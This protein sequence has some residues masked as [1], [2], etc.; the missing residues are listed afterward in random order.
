MEAMDVSTSRRPV[1]SLPVIAAILVFAGGLLDITLLGDGDPYWHVEVGRWIASHHEVPVRDFYSYTFPGLAWTA[2]EWLS[3]LL[4]FWV[5]SIAGWQGINILVCGMFALTTAYMLRFLLDRMP[6]VSAITTCVVCVSVMTVHFYGRPHVF[7]WPMTALWVGTLVKAGE[8]HQPP[9]L[10]LLPM[11]IVWANLHASFTLGLGF[12]GALALDAWFLATPGEERNTLVR[13]WSIFL[14]A[15]GACVLINPRGIG[16]ITHAIGVMGMKETLDI[17]VEW[18]SADFHQFQYLLLWIA[19]VMIASLTG[20]LRLSP[21][22]IIFILGLLYLALK[23]RR[24]H[25][26]VGLVSPF[27]LARPLGEGLRRAGTTNGDGT[28]LGAVDGFPLAG[29]A[30]P[31]GAVI[32]V[33]AC[34]GLLF[35]LY[36]RIPGAPNPYI[37]PTA[38]LQAFRATGIRANVLNTYGFGGYLIYEHVPVFI[39]G[40]G[41]MYGD[42]FMQEAEDANGLKKPHALDSVLTKY[43]IGWTL[44]RPNTAAVELLDHLPAWERLYGDSIGVVHVRRDL[45]PATRP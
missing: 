7:V 6:A 14:A 15:A 25:A 35:S 42:K 29:R 5:W 13:R 20:R 45:M 40:R 8:E 9:P 31:L 27:L 22:R 33:A 38:A 39:D 43:R 30:G 11:L 4:M 44:L 17:V 36:A 24:Y 21:I 2:H 10:W 16:A 32:G 12:A 34:I 28:S 23:H 1:V 3:E 19:L 41:D 37:T 18:K 26:L